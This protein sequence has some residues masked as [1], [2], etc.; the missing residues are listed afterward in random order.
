M[1][2]SMKIGI[3]G[4]NNDSTVDGVLAEVKAAERDGFASYWQ[5]QIFGLDALSTLSVV[6]HQVPR[7]ELG[8]SVIPTYPRHPMML[9]QQALTANQASGGRLCLGI[10]LSRQLVIEGMLKLSFDKPLRHM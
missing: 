8:T 3:F 5:S 2:N 10:G 1:T 9:A 6:G 7:I 4:S